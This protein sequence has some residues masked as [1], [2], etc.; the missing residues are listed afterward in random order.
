MASLKWRLSRD[1]EDTGT[2]YETLEDAEKGMALLIKPEVHE[3]DGHGQ[4]WLE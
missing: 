3:Y 4:K 1:G 2:D